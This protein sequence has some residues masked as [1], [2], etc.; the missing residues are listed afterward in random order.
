MCSCN[1]PTCGVAVLRR[2]ID[3]F[4]MICLL[5]PNPLRNDTRAGLEKSYESFNN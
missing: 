5:Y 4:I 1:L 2:L 3:L